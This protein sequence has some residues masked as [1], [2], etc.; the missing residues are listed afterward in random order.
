MQTIKIE[1][2]N[3]LLQFSSYMHAKSFTHADKIII[4]SVEIKQLLLI[5]LMQMNCLTKC[6]NEKSKSY[7]NRATLKSELH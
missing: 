7:F 1:R 2:M 5:Y 4:F 6:E 3:E